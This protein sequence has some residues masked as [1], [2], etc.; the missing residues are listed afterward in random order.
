MSFE[1]PLGLQIAGRLTDTA[2][3]YLEAPV[4]DWKDRAIALPDGLPLVMGSKRTADGATGSHILLLNAALREDRPDVVLYAVNYLGTPWDEHF[5][6]VVRLRIE[7][8]ANAQFAVHSWR[9]FREVFSKWL[10][11]ATSDISQ[12]DGLGASLAQK[13]IL[14]S[15][16][17]RTQDPLRAQGCALLVELVN[18]YGILCSDAH[19]RAT[20]SPLWA[21]EV[22]QWRANCDVTTIHKAGLRELYIYLGTVQNAFAQSTALAPPPTLASAPVRAS[23]LFLPTTPTQEAT[24]LLQCFA[25][26]K[27]ALARVSPLFEHLRLYQ[28]PGYAARSSVFTTQ[29]RGM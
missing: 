22:A 29:P 16:C 12:L 28:A 11:N 21:A 2:S 6:D 17:M 8:W 13:G 1:N 27:T 7:A 5:P 3:E 23:Q 18:S 10:S 25:P 26:A 14:V 20:W 24:L 4:A 15:L 9:R 19:F